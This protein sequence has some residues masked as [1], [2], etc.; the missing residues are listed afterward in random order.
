MIDL[1]GVFLPAVTPFVPGTGEVDLPAMQENLR[2]W[3][4]HPIRGVVIAGTTGEAV[5]LDEEERLELVRAAREALQPEHPV[6][7]GHRAGIDPGN[8]SPQPEGG[9]CRGR[10]RAGPTSGLLQGSHDARKPCGSTIW[11]WRTHPRFPSSFIR[12][13]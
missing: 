12:H 10:R 11:P 3:S 2:R 13:P 5:L 8:G 4:E 9:G 7:G 6:D 1:S